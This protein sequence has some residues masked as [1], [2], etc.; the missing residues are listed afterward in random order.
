MVSPRCSLGVCRVHPHSQR[1][2]SLPFPGAVVN[3]S[4]PPL[5][6]VPPCPPPHVGPATSAPLSRLTP[7]P[8]GASDLLQPPPAHGGMVY[9]LLPPPQMVSPASHSPAPSLPAPPLC[10]TSLPP[11]AHDWL[12]RNAL[13]EAANGDA[14]PARTQDGAAGGC[15]RVAVRRPAGGR[16]LPPRSAAAPRGRPAGGLAPSLAGWP[17]GPAPPLPSAMAAE[18]GRQFW[19][20]SAKLPGR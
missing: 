10:R 19:K 7:R 4:R 14:L 17:A 3:H 1:E 15:G 20:R 2:W 13:L 11:P 16:R 8:S 9:L 18:S 5:C 12:I 6:R